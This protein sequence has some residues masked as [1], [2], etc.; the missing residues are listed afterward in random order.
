MHVTVLNIDREAQLKEKTHK[1]QGREPSQHRETIANILSMTGAACIAARRRPANG[2][3]RRSPRNT[4]LPS[5]S[6]P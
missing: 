1:L 6:T 5:V 4:V 3:W 2:G